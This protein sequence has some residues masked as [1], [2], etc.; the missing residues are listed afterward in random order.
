LTVHSQDGSKQVY[1]AEPDGKL[2]G[3]NRDDDGFAAAFA[4]L[5]PRLALLAEGQVDL[6]ELYRS[7]RRND[8]FTGAVVQALQNKGIPASALTEL[9][10]TV[11]RPARAQ[12]EAE[13][14]TDGARERKARTAAGKTGSGVQVQ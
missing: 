5:H 9:D 7:S 13:A 6:R 12:E 8:R 4:T 1:L 10:H 2:T 11:K 3:L 14:G